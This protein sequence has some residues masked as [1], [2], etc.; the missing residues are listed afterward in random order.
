MIAGERLDALLQNLNSMK[1]LQFYVN[2]INTF[3]FF[4]Y[5]LINASKSE[6]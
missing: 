5:I 2:E 3:H 4:I 6:V 1:L